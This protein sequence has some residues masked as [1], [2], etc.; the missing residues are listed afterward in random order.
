MVRRLNGNAM[1]FKYLWVISVELQLNELKNPFRYKDLIN[2]LFVLAALT[3]SSRTKPHGQN[4]AAINPYNSS[5]LSI[6]LCDQACHDDQF[7]NGYSVDTLTNGCYLSRCNMFY[8]VPCSTCSAGS[9]IYPTTNPY[10]PTPGSSTEKTTQNSE[11]NGTR[12]TDNKM[13]AWCPCMCKNESIT[14]VELMKMRR[15][16]L[17]VEK[18][19][20]SAT[21]RKRTCA[22]DS[23]TSS[24]VIGMVSVII[25]IACGS[26]IIGSDVR[27]VLH[28][29]YRKCNKLF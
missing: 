2:L 23:R 20:L 1:S 7:C 13:E 11:K 3:E 21:I 17:L 22:T 29:C 15:K 16:E 27:S 14:I 18:S 6:L 5:T 26:M 8:D 12:S 10:C 25:L 4:K 9:K 24:T 28:L 19:K